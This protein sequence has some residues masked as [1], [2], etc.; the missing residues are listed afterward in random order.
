VST[1][2][3]YTMP[4]DRGTWDVPATGTSRFSWEYPSVVVWQAGVPRARLV[5]SCMAA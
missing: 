4:A 5:I 2:D 1:Y 3:R